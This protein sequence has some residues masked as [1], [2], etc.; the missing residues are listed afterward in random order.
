MESDLAETIRA[1]R[2]RAFDPG[3]KAAARPP[4]FRTREPRPKKQKL[5]LGDDPKAE[6]LGFIDLT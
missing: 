1:A 4:D 6:S 2:L 5:A 3:W